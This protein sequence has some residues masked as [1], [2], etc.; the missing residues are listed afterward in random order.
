MDLDFL[1]NKYF[2]AIFSILSGLY[3]AQIR[4]TLPNFIMDLF[5]NPCFRVVVL[6]LVVLRSYKDPQFS[7]IIAI[8]FV[9]IMNIVNEQLFKDTFANINIQESTNEQLCSD[10]NLN[11]N[12]IINCIN[13]IDNYTS[14]SEHKK[15]NLDK[16]YCMKINNSNTLK[17]DTCKNV[18]IFP[19]QIPTNVNC[20]EKYKLQPNYEIGTINS[21]CSNVF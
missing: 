12:L 9:I 19:R 15:K 21:D 2:L 20:I 4:P 3:A 1:E 13:D 18:Q 16:L 10:I 8:S 14:N 11:K 17:G 5:Q 6:F 7:L